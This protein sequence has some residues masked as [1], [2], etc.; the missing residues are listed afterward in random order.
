MSNCDQWDKLGTLTQKRREALE[1]T[2]K[3]LETIEQLYLEFAKRAAP[4]NNWMEGA[5][6]DLQDMFIVHSVE[7]TQ[8]LIAAHEQFKA[9]LPEADSERQAILGIHSEKTKTS[10]ET[11]DFRACLISMGYDPGEVEFARIMT[12]VDPNGTCVVSFQSFI[13]FM[14]RET[15]DT[16]CCRFS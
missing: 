3:L 13:D 14:I 9:I 12:L 2:E 8:S 4:F 11:D 16:T 10:M 6:E 1:R 7:E 5:M 15:A